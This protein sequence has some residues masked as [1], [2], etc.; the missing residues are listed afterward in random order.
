MFHFRLVFV[1]N[2]KLK[3]MQIGQPKSLLK[4]PHFAVDGMATA[5][6]LKK[7]QSV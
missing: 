6:I 4:E 2:H 3:K 7:E 5:R 1:L